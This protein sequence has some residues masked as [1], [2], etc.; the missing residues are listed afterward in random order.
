MN[1]RMDTVYTTVNGYGYSVL[2]THATV[3]TRYTATRWACDMKH[4]T[5]NNDGTALFQQWKLEASP[6][7]NNP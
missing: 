4:V 5:C 3:L 7:V 1:R 6:D 2:D